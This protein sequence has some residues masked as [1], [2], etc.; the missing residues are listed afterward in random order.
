MISLTGYHLTIPKEKLD[1]EQ[2]KKL[3]EL[4]EDLQL[5]LNEDEF[6]LSCSAISSLSYLQPITNFL[7]KEVGLVG[8][9]DDGKYIDYVMHKTRYINGIEPIGNDSIPPDWLTGK[10]MNIVLHKQDTFDTKNIISMALGVD[11]NM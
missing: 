2:M 3:R 10:A 11:L 6:L 8:L 5:F 7:Q 9:N 1:K 4:V